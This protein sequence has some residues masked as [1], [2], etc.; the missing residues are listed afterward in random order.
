ME[1]QVE[2]EVGGLRGGKKGIK[3]GKVPLRQDINNKERK[4]KKEKN[5]S[6]MSKSQRNE[7]G[8]YRGLKQVIAEK[9]II[10]DYRELKQAVKI[11]EG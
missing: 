8:G 9:I 7:L 2:A 3:E 10:K 5:L 6:K 11:T 1:T 4:K